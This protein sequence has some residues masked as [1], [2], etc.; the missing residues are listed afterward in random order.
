MRARSQTHPRARAHAHEKKKSW[1]EFCV[2]NHKSFACARDATPLLRFPPRVDLILNSYLAFRLLLSKSLFVFKRATSLD[3]S[4]G[5]TPQQIAERDC[6]QEW[7]CD[8]GAGELLW[9]E[10]PLLHFFVVCCNF[11][12]AAASAASL[13]V[14]LKFWDIWHISHFP[15]TTLLIQRLAC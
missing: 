10:Y 12:A 6:G 8:G 13:G 1:E 2:R 5:K 15:A 9:G 4:K 11:H 7:C 14:R 3:I